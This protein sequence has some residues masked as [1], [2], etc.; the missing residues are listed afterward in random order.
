MPRNKYPEETIQTILDVSWRLF[1][2]KGYEQTTILDIVDNMGGLTRGAFY[3]HFKSKEEVLDAIFTKLH[4]D[5]EPFGSVTDI[6][7]LTGLE[8]IRSVLFVSLAEHERSKENME[9]HKA[10]LSLLH[11]PH[12]LAAHLQGK[13]DMTKW[14]V[15]LI[16]E[17]MKDGSIRYSNPKVLAEL[18]LMLYGFWCTSAVYPGSQDE[19][20][21]KL[22][23]T[24]QILDST[25]FPI[26]NAEVMEGLTQFNKSVQRN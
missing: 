23:L 24:K 15:P 8:K 21:D 13:L 6:E 11:N 9:L 18:F 20:A 7:E 5:N 4:R 12:I 19:F 14:L 25:G 10:G 17:G 2:E 26:I 16:E 22:T 3:H 1:L